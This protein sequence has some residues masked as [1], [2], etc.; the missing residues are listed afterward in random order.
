MSYRVW[1]NSSC[2]T[3]APARRSV[4]RAENDAGNFYSPKKGPRPLSIKEAFSF[5]GPGPELINGRLAMLGFI[6]SAA[7]ELSSGQTVFQ[8]FTGPS[9]FWVVYFSALTSVAS[10]IPLTAEGV[11]DTK[12]GPFTPAAEKLNGRAAMV[13]IAVMIFYEAVKQVPLF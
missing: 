4:V 8:Q 12:Y 9:Q 1:K 7:A 5:Y 3:R 10:L 2:F 13:G 11:T 6:A